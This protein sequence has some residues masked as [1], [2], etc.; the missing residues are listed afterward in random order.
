MGSEYSK[1]PERERYVLINKEKRK[2][3]KKYWVEGLAKKEKE[4]ELIEKSQKRNL[5]DLGCNEVPEKD[6]DMR[7]L[8]Q[9]NYGRDT[10]LG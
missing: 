1:V 4:G 5:K 7:N 10:T 9:R 2:Q 6:I 3:G 8:I